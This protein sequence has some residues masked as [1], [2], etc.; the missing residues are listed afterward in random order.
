[1]SGTD[2]D[3]QEAYPRLAET[4]IASLAPLA[5]RRRI[6]DGEPLFE[7]GER[8]GGV[9]VVL[10]GAVEIVDRSGDESQTVTVH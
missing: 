9:F 3:R 4:D 10:E 7:A 6:R 8:R 1:M 2:S 5:T